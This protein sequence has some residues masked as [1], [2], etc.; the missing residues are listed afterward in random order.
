[1]FV[2]YVRAQDEVGSAELVAAVVETSEE[3]S[4]GGRAPAGESTEAAAVARVMEVLRGAGLVADA[5]RALLPAA[6]GGEAGHAA[7]ERYLAETADAGAAAWMAQQ[8]ALAFLA[9]AL[10][11]GCSLQGRSFTP[12]EAS[13]AVV[14]TCNLGLESWPPSWG[15]SSGYGLVTVFQVGWAVLH[16]D[17]SMAAAAQLMAALAQIQSTDRDLQFGLAVLRREL[18]KQHAAGTP[19]RVRE[20][21]EVLAT[22]DLVTWAALAALFDEYPVMLANV[23]PGGSHALTVTP[24]E[25]QSIGSGGDI[26]AVRAF[27]M[28]L[29]ELLVS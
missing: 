22:L 11:A 18:R 2:A 25:F 9:N 17:V 3:E 7:L 1:V 5:P 27:L 14:A 13:D 24:S 20:R 12:R 21:L 23:R 28:R 8:Q 26:A 10:A 16:R 6:R 19:W 29:P 4:P 15:E